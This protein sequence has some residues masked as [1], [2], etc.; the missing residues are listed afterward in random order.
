MDMDRK[1]VESLRK[2][3]SMDNLSEEEY[4][5][6]KALLMRKLTQ[7]A[8]KFLYEKEDKDKGPSLQKM[9]MKKEQDEKMARAKNTLSSKEESDDS[10][11]DETKSK[12]NFSR[13]NSS[14]FTN[15]NSVMNSTIVRTGT[16]L[17]D[18]SSSCDEDSS[19]LDT[20]NDIESKQSSEF[21]ELKEL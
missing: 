1:I 2:L 9:A 17:S 11:Q 12:S 6:K 3:Q 5:K 20:V 13:K 14:R 21:D 16:E 15:K 19:N 7:K 10:N 4:Y 18:C 8:T